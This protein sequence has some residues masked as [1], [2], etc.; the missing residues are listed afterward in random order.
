[1]M[2]TQNSH[3]GE[4]QTFTGLIRSVETQ[5]QLG[6]RAPRPRFMTKC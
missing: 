3:T 5:G 2:T 1:M 6:L 4:V